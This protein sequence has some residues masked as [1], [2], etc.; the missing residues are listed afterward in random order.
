MGGFRSIGDVKAEELKQMLDQKQAFVLVDNRTE[1][2]FKE[3]H[4]PGSINIPAHRFDVIG[5]LLPSDKKA[6]L[7]FYCRGT[8]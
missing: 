4:I 7:I 2:E 8:G 3:G 5:T 6:R 1:Y